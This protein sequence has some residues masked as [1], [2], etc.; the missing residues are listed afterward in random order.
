MHLYEDM[1]KINIHLKQNNNMAFNTRVSD[2][3]LV[4]TPSIITSH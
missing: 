2:N 1:L 3:A 4:V